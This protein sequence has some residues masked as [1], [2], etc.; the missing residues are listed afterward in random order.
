MVD[1]ESK[2]TKV[3]RAGATAVSG[4]VVTLITAPAGPF[5][6]SVAASVADRMVNIMV[7]WKRDR[8]RKR[9]R[10]FVGEY[11][12]G[13]GDVDPMVA[14][15]E[16]HAFGDQ[17]YV[18]ELVLEAARGLDEALADVVVPALGRL[19]RLYASTG[20]RADGFFRGMRRLLQELNAEAFGELLSF[21]RLVNEPLTAGPGIVDVDAAKAPFQTPNMSHILHL[22]KANLL[23]HDDGV[24]VW[25]S[26]HGPF[27]PSEKAIVKCSTARQMLAI[28]DPNEP[29]RW[30]A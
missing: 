3:V 4:G 28:I 15:A 22:M 29:L 26:S 27:L 7:D 19:A 30:I 11:V 8:V 25:G 17:P 16:L 20:R 1:D 13:E 10:E 9:W 14:E 21:L 23:A 5:V 24:G 12:K 18:Q 2:S 6:A